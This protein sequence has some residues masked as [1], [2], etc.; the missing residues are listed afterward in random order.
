MELKTFII[1]KDLTKSFVWDITEEIDKIIY[2]K[3]SINMKIT[4]K[5]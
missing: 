5:Y 1:N 2:K 3:G 4:K